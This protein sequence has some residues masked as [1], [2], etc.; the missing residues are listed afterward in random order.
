MRNAITIALTIA[1]LAGC[2]GNQADQVTLTNAQEAAHRVHVRIV[3]ATGGVALN[4]TFNLTAG[5]AETRALGTLYGKYNISI[6]S[7]G[8]IESTTLQF[9]RNA[10]HLY[11]DLSKEPGNPIL[12][13]IAH[14]D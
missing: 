6:D 13:R 2:V 14:G 9:E 8:A 3:D 11:V 1:T 5:A 12:I 7:D 4:E 10:D